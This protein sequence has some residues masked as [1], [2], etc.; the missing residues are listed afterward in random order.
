M[1]A[2]IIILN[3]SEFLT[4]GIKAIATFQYRRK[5][6]IQHLMPELPQMHHFSYDIMIIKK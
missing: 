4:R 5:P 3:H 6:K 1:K 2:R